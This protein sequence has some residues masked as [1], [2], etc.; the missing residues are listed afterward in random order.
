MTLIERLEA[1][2]SQIDAIIVDGKLTIMEVFSTL[3]IIAG[4]VKDTIAE[5]PTKPT[6]AEVEDMLNEGW[7]WADT[8]YKLV[9]KADAAIKL[10]ILL[11]ALDGMLI[12]IVIEKTAIPALAKKLAA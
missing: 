11:E 7:N 6:E 3:E 1:V 2:A 4:A 10:P 9:D 8:K 5:M 12:R